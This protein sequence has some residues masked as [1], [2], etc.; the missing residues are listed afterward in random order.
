LSKTTDPMG[1]PEYREEFEI[2]LNKQ[3][4]RNS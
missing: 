1:Q 3:A 2:A 4:S